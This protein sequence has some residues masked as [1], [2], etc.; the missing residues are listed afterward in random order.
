MAE[1]LLYQGK[2]SQAKKELELYLK[3]KDIGKSNFTHYY[4]KWFLCDFLSANFDDS[5]RKVK[6]AKNIFNY[7][8]TPLISKGNKI[9]IA[10]ELKKVI[11]LDPLSY[12]AWYNYAVSMSGEK[13]DN[14]FFEW[15][16]TSIL[17]FEDIESWTNALC[18]MIQES[19]D[20]VD[21]TLSWSFI[22]QAVEKFN[23]ALL[24]SIE[25]FYKSQD[26]IDEK[27]ID[28]IITTFKNMFNEA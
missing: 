19:I 9:K 10:D 18:S 4:L 1:A 5:P 14:I 24:I 3:E 28:N 21:S 25:K 27:T 16:I 6:E 22:H 23:G 7:I 13:K 8:V 2:Y 11:D 26:G 20:K 15:A 12:F 17:N